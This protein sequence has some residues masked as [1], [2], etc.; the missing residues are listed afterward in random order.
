[1]GKAI[2]DDQLGR[3]VSVRASW[4][5]DLRAEPLRWRFQSKLSGPGVVADLGAHIFDLLLWWLG[6]PRRVLGRC[7]TLVPQRPAEIGG[8]TLEVDVPDE[9]WALLEFPHQG[10]GC[11]SLS[12]NA[13]RDQKVE[14]EGTRA[15]L[16]YDSPSLLQWLSGA[17]PF[18]PS[19][20]LAPTAA[21]SRATQLPLP[22]DHG[23]SS[24]DDALA[25]MF[26]Q[27]VDY[28]RGGEKPHSLPSF[29]DGA[30]VIH[31]IDALVESNT[32][33]AWTEVTPGPS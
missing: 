5:V 33:G 32:T 19:V 21:P 12:W 4:G 17:G 29:R 13:E 9:C 27:I 14:I 1:M 26:R 24:P 23:F 6:R 22:D 28:L 25:H 11:V 3:L 8:R 2:A 15:R 10:V 31:V 30:R 18:Q 16:T 7:Q 20:T